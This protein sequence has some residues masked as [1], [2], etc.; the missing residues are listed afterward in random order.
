AKL[1]Q[2]VERAG[3]AP[4]E[5]GSITAFYTVLTEGDDLQDPVADAARAILDGHV[6]LSRELA[7][8]GHYPAID[9]EASISRAL[10]ELVDGQHLEQIR[11]FRQLYTSYR[12]ARDLIMVGAYARGSDPLVDRAMVLYPKMMEFLR[13]DLNTKLRF[14]QSTSSLSALMGLSGG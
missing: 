11:Q 1:P 4:D 8:Q 2:L 12:R 3:N 9:V 13:Q 6:V 7:D 14:E 10:T 5:R